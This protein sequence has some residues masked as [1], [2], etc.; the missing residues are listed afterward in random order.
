ME[1]AAE[2]IGGRYRGRE[3]E[4]NILLPGC[5]RMVETNNGQQHGGQG[6]L[7]R[8][9]SQHDIPMSGLRSATVHQLRKKTGAVPRQRR[10]ERIS[11][12]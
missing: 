9:L 12:T 3:A 8:M 10:C 5:H 2:D 6:Q 1:I 4:T 11:Y 7:P